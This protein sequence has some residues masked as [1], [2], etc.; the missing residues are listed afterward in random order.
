MNRKGRRIGI[1]PLTQ[2]VSVREFSRFNAT[3]NLSFFDDWGGPFSSVTHNQP[4][5]PTIRLPQKGML[6]LDSNEGTLPGVGVTPGS[7][8]AVFEEIAAIHGKVG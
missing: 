7:R 1:P 3:Q 4:R 2:L 6:P 8:T 5:T